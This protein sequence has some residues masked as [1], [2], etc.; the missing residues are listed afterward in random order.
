MAEPNPPPEA[1]VVTAAS[2]PPPKGGGIMG[3]IIA[4][5]IIVAGI[6]GVF[7]YM[8][9]PA[10]NP[11]KKEVP[12]GLSGEGDEGGDSHGTDP[13]GDETM[14]KVP[15]ELPG[16]ILVNIKGENNKVL[17]AKVGFLLKTKVKDEK[18]EKEL[19]IILGKFNSLLTAAVRSYF[20]SLDEE[21]LSNPEKMHKDQLKAKLNVVF[22]KLRSYG[23]GKKEGKLVD[24]LMGDPV[25]EVYL[26]YFTHQ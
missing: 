22:A 16:S 26:P 23:H 18:K 6:A 10:L 1:E 19:Q 7:S 25:E 21:S 12:T 17:S 8:V 15:Y 13:S 5:I 4:A 2:A 24:L 3:P 11:E 9:V 20:V 14:M